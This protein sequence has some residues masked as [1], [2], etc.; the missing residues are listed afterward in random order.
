MLA[1]GTVAM[2]NCKL[3]GKVSFKKGIRE[4][5]DEANLSNF[6]TDLLYA[7]STPPTWNIFSVKSQ[8]PTETKT[9]TVVEF[10]RYREERKLAIC[11]LIFSTV[12]PGTTI[13][14][15]MHPINRKLEEM[16]LYRPRPLESVAMRIISLSMLT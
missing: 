5:K 10:V 11:L 4:E 3:H 1:G 9:L 8:I 6:A 16:K 2:H 12:P 7:S 13:T 14:L 15:R